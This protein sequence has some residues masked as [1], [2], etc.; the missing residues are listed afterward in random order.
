M[1]NLLIL[2]I[3]EVKLLFRRRRTLIAF[4]IYIFSVLSIISS[5]AYYQKYFQQALL[6]MNA[7]NSEIRRLLDQNFDYDPQQLQ[8]ILD[9]L[10]SWPTSFWLYQVVALIFIPSLIAL[11]SSDM[12][13]VDRYRE[14]LRYLLLRTSRSSYYFSK[15]LAHTGVYLCLHI[16]SLLLLLFM[17]I[18]TGDIHNTDKYLHAVFYQTV[19]FL[20]FTICI[21]SGTAW[22]SALCKKPQTA[23]LLVHAFWMFCLLIL[24]WYPNLS[25]FN[26]PNLIGIVFPAAELVSTAALG[27]GIW[28]LIFSMIGYT[29]FV[30]KDL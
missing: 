1:R 4:I 6:T 26:A 16:A 21:V 30:R 12:I 19:V 23:L 8:M 27:L 20:P 11:A 9:F 24:G 13:A 15:V 10:S 7:R 17:L 3:F 25:P 14:T 29:S 5:L 22:M 18:S 2:S 28:I